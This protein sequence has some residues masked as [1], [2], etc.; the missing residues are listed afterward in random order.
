MAL[1]F[2]K[3]ERL[4]KSNMI[5]LLLM[6]FLLT[7]Y[8]F[9]QNFINGKIID[10]NNKPIYG[11]NIYITETETGTSTNFEG[12]FTLKLPNNISRFE[13][14]ISHIGFKKVNKIIS[15]PLH[16]ELIITLENETVQFNEVVVTENRDG[17]YLKNSPVRIEVLT[18]KE[19]ER[20]FGID[21]TKSLNFSPG[22]KVQDN[23]GVCGTT[24]I[25]I[26]GLEGQY[27]Q[28]LIDGFPIISNL[29]TV[30]GLLGIHPFFVKQIEIIK[31][32]GTII[33]GP[34]A[35][36]GTINIILKKPYEIP[37]YTFS[38]NSTTHKE[39]DFS[40]A[41]SEKFENVATSLIANLSGAFD[42]MD[43]NNDGF[44]DIP[45]F[46]R[47]SL[48]NQWAGKF[49]DDLTFNIN[50]RYY[51]E[52]RFGGE[53]NWDKKLHRGSN[54]VY[55]ES[56]YSKRQ[57]FFGGLRKQ[58]S[59]NKFWQINF[60]Q[61]W[62]NQNSYYGIYKLDANQLT[63]YLDY[64]YNF[65][66][67]NNNSW[68][69]G[70]AYKIEK[71]DDNTPAT[72]NYSNSTINE[73]SF[74]HTASLFAQQ[75]YKWN[76]DI[77]SLAGLRFNYHNK[78]K[79]I[80]QPRLSL[81][82]SPL[83]NSTF[84]FSFGTGFRTV[85][86]FTEDHAVLTGSRELIINN[87]IKPEKSINGTISFVQDLDF[88]DSWGRF[89]FSTHLTRFSNQIIPNYNADVNKIIYDNLIGFSISKGF[90]F[91]LNYQFNFPFNINFSYEFLETFKEESGLKS[92]IEFN[93][94]HKI[95]IKLNYEMLSLNSEISIS[96]KWV[97]T[98]KLPEFPIEFN[99]DKFSK[100]YSLW[101]VTFIKNFDLLKL[102][103]GV[104]NIFNYV[105]DSPLIDPQ[106][107]FGENFDT[108]YIYGPLHSREI[109]AG[110]LFNIN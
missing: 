100:N 9:S 22:I 104:K 41:A 68:T 18:Q 73:P 43:M 30:Y 21:I 85:N 47:I 40:L 79:L 3:K 102:Q 42:R 94:K 63:A 29:G 110:I 55:G 70:T 67:N 39:H 15:F 90:E 20:N 65:I 34:E 86:I 60:S 11:V 62:H 51:Y 101:D 75:E 106:N 48:L 13:I 14:I 37:R 36:S 83:E 23:C 81:K 52:E 6:F 76:E 92:E 69:I 64:L 28:I 61:V 105:Q 16:E 97:G 87:H 96:G 77:T 93:P 25:R 57:E 98:Q 109:F 45:E 103:F 91:N 12:I 89:E 10:I 107:P 38:I 59:Q 8:S 78:Q 84:R 71:Y 50:L 31:G 46:H 88:Y 99:K 5:N 58:V 27:S 33:Y 108:T 56:I 2:P 24:D 44:T 66:L 35:I 7:V 54:T 53:I 80:L 74:S 49:L 1:Q 32:P 17:I 72:M 82:Y 26:Q 19:L 4:K 95:N